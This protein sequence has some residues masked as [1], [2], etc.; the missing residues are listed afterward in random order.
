MEVRC[1]S[2]AK[3]LSLEEAMPTTPS[4]VLST[5]LV[6]VVLKIAS[7]K[8]V[9]KWSQPHPKRFLHRLL[10]LKKLLRSDG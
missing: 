10:H 5:L 8:T 3:E 6:K 1:K 4:M 9:K 7:L 2:I